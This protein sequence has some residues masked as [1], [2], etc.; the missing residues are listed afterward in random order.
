M[1]P[2]RV[3]GATACCDKRVKIRQIDADERPELSLPVQVYGF[4]PSPASG[5][6]L[7][8]LRDNQRYFRD[9]ITPIAEADGATIAAGRPQ[10]S[11][12]CLGQAGGATGSQ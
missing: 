10:V 6:E 7:S 5:T 8:R 12:R 3:T 4:Q 9:D 2:L 11:V 1:T